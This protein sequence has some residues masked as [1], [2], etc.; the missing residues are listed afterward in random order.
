MAPFKPLRA[1]ILGSELTFEVDPPHVKNSEPLD[2]CGNRAPP[3]YKL[4][5]QEKMNNFE[6]ANPNLCF[7][8]MS[9]EV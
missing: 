7:R 6:A 1:K 8:R 4:P 9:A 3:Q 5:A 2:L